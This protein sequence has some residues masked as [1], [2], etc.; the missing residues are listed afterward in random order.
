MAPLRKNK[1][2]FCK[3]FQTRLK[4]KLTSDRAAFIKT[5]TWYKFGHFIISLSSLPVSLAKETHLCV[6]ILVKLATGSPCNW[7]R[8]LCWAFYTN[9]RFFTHFAG[10]ITTIRIHSMKFSS[11][12]LGLCLSIPLVHAHDTTVRVSFVCSADSLEM[13]LSSPALLFSQVRYCHP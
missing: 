11:A 5:A 6:S 2:M 4:A 7:F 3:T 8:V 1:S 12:F 10:F 13:I 9:I